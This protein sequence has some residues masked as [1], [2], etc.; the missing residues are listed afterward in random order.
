MEVMF[1]LLHWQQAT[2]SARTWPLEILEILTL[3]VSLTWLLYNLELDIH[4]F[5]RA[6]F[7]NSLH[8]FGHL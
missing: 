8:A 7:E 5:T 1:L 2:Q 4:D 3:K 6:D